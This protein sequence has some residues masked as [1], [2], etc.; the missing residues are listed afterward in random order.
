MFSTYDA[1]VRALAESFLRD[2]ETESAEHFDILSH[3]L[4]GRIQDAI[5]EF[6]EEKDLQ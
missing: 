2:R 1:K 5:D 3:L 6:L 4:A